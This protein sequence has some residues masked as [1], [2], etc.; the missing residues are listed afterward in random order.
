MTKNLLKFAGTFLMLGTVSV[1]ISSCS[2]P[3]PKATAL[4]SPRSRQIFA[5]AKMYK[6]EDLKYRSADHS[7]P[8]AIVYITPDFDGSK[9][10]NLM[11]YNHGMMTNLI[12]VE[13]TWKISQAVKDA[14]P[15]TVLVAPEWAAKPREISA[16]AGSFHK[17]G[18]FRNHLEEVFSRVPELADKSIDRDVAN[19][20]LTSFSGGL[21]VLGS[22]LYKNG[23]EDK[24][25][26][27]ALFDSLYKTGVIEPWL[28]KNIRALAG[29]EK[30]YYNFYFHTYPRS[31]QQAKMVKKLLEQNKIEPTTCMRWDTDSPNAIMKADRI[32]NRPIIFKYSINGDEKITGH[33][34]VPMYYIPQFMK[35]MSQKQQAQMVAAKT[36]AKTL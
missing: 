29:G 16:N 22:E 10:I 6:L 25:K 27:V 30:Q 31:N 7:T 36:T 28:K 13:E 24:V 20:T 8:D 2:P 1:A 14:P 9:P 18:F 23:L 11:I 33:N 3:E 35:A 12:D 5:E 26:A 15:N 19:I 4:E 34:A 21:Y 17:P 32:A